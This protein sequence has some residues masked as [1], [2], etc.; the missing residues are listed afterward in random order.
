TRKEL[1]SI[2][3][4]Y[5]KAEI[6]QMEAPD[7]ISNTTM[8]IDSGAYKKDSTYWASVRPVPLTPDEVKGYHKQDSLAVIEK[9]KEAADTLID[10]KHKKYKRMHLIIEYTYKVAKHTNL[11]NHFPM[12]GF[13][14]D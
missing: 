13:N 6:G 5:E 9:K 12:P 2:I 8:T 7:I 3:K 11:K 4:E 10:S 14:T 1:N